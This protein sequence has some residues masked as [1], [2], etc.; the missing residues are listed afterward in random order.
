MCKII[1][2]SKY[3]FCFILF[4]YLLTFSLGAKSLLLIQYS[5]II[6]AG[7][8][9]IIWYPIWVSHK[10]A[11]SLTHCTISVGMSCYFEIY[12]ETCE[13]SLVQEDFL[14]LT[15]GIKGTT[16]P[17]LLLHWITANLPCKP[18]I[19]LSIFIHSS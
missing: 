13:V 9:G 6:L 7:L 2:K 14:I 10:Q 18:T 5:G 8:R 19:S 1:W 4:I 17:S 3:H 12:I 11:I 16:K 15:S